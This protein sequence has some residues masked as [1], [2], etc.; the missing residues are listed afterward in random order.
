M[1]S[2][3]LV[4]NY[5]ADLIKSLHTPLLIE[6]NKQDMRN[7][8][9]QLPQ[10]AQYELPFLLAQKNY[11]AKLTA[12]TT[13][14]IAIDANNYQGEMRF[15]LLEALLEQL[16]DELKEIKNIV[17][18]KETLKA[19]A[20]VATGGLLNEFVGGY[21]DKGV[22]YLFDEVGE[23]FSKLLVDSI[24]DKVDVSNIAI[25]SIEGFLQDYAGDS[26]GEFIGKSSEYKL[27]LSSVAKTELNTLSKAFATSAQHDV[28]QLTFKI[29]LA[30][31]LESPKL[32]YI[33]NPHK[34]DDNSL[35]I[36]S[37]MLSY[38][39][40]QKN[41]DK[42]LGL[43]VVYTYSDDAFQPYTEVADNLKQKQR[44]LDDQRRFAQRYAMLE[45]PSSDIPKVA[46]KSSLFI[47]RVDELRQLKD[48]FCQENPSS[49]KTMVSVVSGEPG[50]GKTALVKH[51]LKQIESNKTI[52]LTLL[53][54]VGH[55]SSN[56][57]LS[58]LEKSILEEATRLD[59]LKTWKEKGVSGLKGL[60]NKDNA[61]KAIGL[62]FSGGD[63]VLNIADS[64][65]Q[66]AMVDN[67]INK[68]KQSGE[69]DLDNQHKDQKT[70]QFDKL[71]Q[72]IDKLLPLSDSSQP[73][74]L[75]IDDCQ[76]IDNNSCEY[77]L[78]RLVNKVPLYI[79]TTIRPSDAST[80]LKQLA[81]EP[82]L[83]EYRIALL[84]TLE[85]NGHKVVQSHVDTGFIAHHT[86]HLIGFNKSALN[87]LLSLVIKA[88]PS[89]IVS[90]GQA[91]FSEIAGQDSNT[92][93]TLFAIESINMLCDE[94]LYSENET[95]ALV[96]DNPLRFNPQ[97][98]DIERSIKETF[99]ILKNKYKD[100]LSHNEKSSG[101]AVFNLMAYAVLEER[102]HLLKL[103]FAERGNAAVN[104][105]LFSSALGA[106]FS[107]N[108]V[109][110][111]LQVLANTEQ[112]LLEPLRSHVKQS[113]QEIG[114]TTEHYAI[115]DEVYE[116]LS[117]YSLNDDKY[118]Y[119]HALLFLF[120]ESQFEHL[121]ET[122]LI[123]EAPQAKEEMYVLIL[124]VIEQEY[125]QQAFYDKAEIDLNAA[126]FEQLLFFK[127][128]ELLILKR[129]FEINKE[130]QWAKRYTACLKNLALS[131]EGNLQSTEAIELK[132]ALRIILK[133]LYQAN[134]ELW[135]EDYINNLND[136]AF[137]LCSHSH[138][139]N[140]AHRSE[141]FEIFDEASVILK[142]LCTVNKSVWGERYISTLNGLAGI[143]S[144]NNELSKSFALREEVMTLYQSLYE[145]D[146]S[147]WGKSY[148]CSLTNAAFFYKKHNRLA[149][150]IVLQE[151]AV[152]IPHSFHK[153]NW[154]SAY[155]GRLIDL[156]ICYKKN[157]QLLEAIE[158]QKA[159]LSIYQ[160]SYGETPIT[161]DNKYS[162]EIERYLQEMARLAMIYKENSQW[163]EAIEVEKAILAISKALSENNSTPW[164][165]WEQKHSDNM[166]ILAT[167]YKN[168]NQLTEAIKWQEKS[169]EL[170]KN[171]R[172]SEHK[173]YSQ[174]R[175]EKMK[176]PDMLK[177]EIKAL[178]T[179]KQSYQQDNALWGEQYGSKLEA[180]AS[181]CFDNSL[182]PEGLQLSAQAIVIF[183]Q[184][185]QGDKKLWGEKYISKLMN[186]AMR[187][188]SNKQFSE[189]IE[190]L[191]E[192][193]VIR[194]PL[195]ENNPSEW[196]KRHT[197]AMSILAMTY[198]ENNQLLE[199]IEMEKETQVIFK[200]L[201][202]TSKMPWVTTAYKRSLNNLAEHYL[203]TEQLKERTRVLSRL[204]AL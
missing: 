89:Q 190:P 13:N 133:S 162:N 27:N 170:R 123:K 175:N 148:I 84:K 83:N 100:S 54:E 132:K 23:H 142:P 137:S 102:L 195:F 66:R 177:Q 60:A 143:Y 149:D 26:L 82:M 198:E 1:H 7:V 92:I 114:L 124:A 174:A 196:A 191:K 51:H 80:A 87:E 85:I 73:L 45:R 180:L 169:L 86:T 165:N 131:Y 126:D 108:I 185:Y 161:W 144:S 16:T 107:S 160:Q 167:S 186:L 197:T 189:A 179:L 5:Q 64:G 61:F 56:T 109:K 154:P 201:Y 76:W 43:S 128:T 75:F 136:L 188:K 40:H 104:T 49:G 93:N 112:P 31:G 10:S 103:H 141:V 101:L 129:V 52:T 172:E 65:Y 21:L 94:K 4:N 17:T 71:D 156:S 110:K 140:Q 183:K 199:A 90:L 115:I 42:Q 111:T 116:I 50:I 22:D 44:L 37:L 28:F 153:F 200:I 24:T 194:K 119:R 63:K 147:L 151:V 125:K 70:L 120:L 178:D 168:N 9:S 105:L 67:H 166:M 36:I 59:L 163:N 62:I 46:V 79:V 19:A 33:N 47:G 122:L 74:L 6:L 81:T 30:I 8:A 58:S 155:I 184:L 202:E 173:E 113:Q 72:A 38:A 48:N 39:K 88:E 176:F 57:G 193:L 181:S 171:I 97:L 25:S 118:K 55:S 203:A 14:I 187:Y 69:E 146:Q 29:L 35:A 98:T 41:L 18:L 15:Y 159:I 78:T 20:S 99:S 53:N 138:F 135:V 192:A 158:L 11:D 121:L 96:I 77:I 157:H 145:S 139:L 150:S 12:K 134:E 68:V 2:L 117:R 182:L 95:T 130:Q 3:K 34:L 204:V 164:V 32:I 127:N 152:S 91:L 106:P